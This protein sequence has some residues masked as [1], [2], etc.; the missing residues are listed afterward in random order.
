MT[1]VNEASNL[2]AGLIVRRENPLFESLHELALHARLVFFA[3]L[4][5]TGK[6]L[7]I[8]Q[9]AHLAHASGRKVELLQWDVARSRFEAGE[10]GRRYPQVAGVTHGMIRIAA[11]LWVRRAVAEWHAS[12]HDD[13]GLLIGETPFVGH[14]F[15]E[16]AQPARDEAEAVL[17]M[18]TTRFV[19]PVPSSE[20]R[21]HMEAERERRARHPMHEREKEDAPPAVLR[22]MW[23]Q[24]AVVAQALGVGPADPGTAVDAPYDPTVYRDVYLRIL[25]RRHAQA[26]AVDT[27]LPTAAMS[28]YQFS[29]PHTDVA[30]SDDEVA[31]F[32]Q[33]A[34]ARFPTAEALEREIDRW[35]VPAESAEE[36]GL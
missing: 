4:P 13:R 32:M 17:N 3:G 29:V 5:G 12:H 10:A 25:S 34:E 24:L 28:A 20:V 21:Q 11:G 30:P 8:H 22:D 18:E 23:R 36:A 2:P 27:I 7:L 15:S 31:H 33:V 9:L 6:S 14:R 35:Y 19:V 26:L 1:K 16:L